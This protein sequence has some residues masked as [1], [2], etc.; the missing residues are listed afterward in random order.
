MYNDAFHLKYF[1]SIQVLP[2]SSSFDVIYYSFSTNPQTVMIFF[3]T[4]CRHFIILSKEIE[5]EKF[6]MKHTHIQVWN[7]LWY[8]PLN[9]NVNLKMLSVLD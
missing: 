4:I 8:N 1:E 9:S 7:R 5:L 6:H 2:S 3:D